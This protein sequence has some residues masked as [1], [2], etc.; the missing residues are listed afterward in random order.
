MHFDIKHD[1]LSPPF[2]ELPVDAS[3]S[4]TTN[5]ELCH[6]GFLSAIRG[7]PNISLRFVANT[8]LPGI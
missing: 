1:H 3:H 6:G 5:F 8:A 4:R 7:A 2:L